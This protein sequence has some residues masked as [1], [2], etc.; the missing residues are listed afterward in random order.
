MTPVPIIL[1]AGA[2]SRLGGNKARTEIAGLPII[3][4]HLQ[5]ICAAG[6]SKPIVVTGSEADSVEALVRKDG[7]RSV[8]NENWKTGQTS[9]LLCGL[10]SLP[11]KAAGFFILPV[12]HACVLVTDWV[13]LFERFRAAGSKAQSQIFRPRC[14]D[15]LGHPVLFGREFLPEFL[16]LDEQTPGNTVYRAHLDQVVW[17][18]VSNPMIGL[19]VDTPTARQMAELWFQDRGVSDG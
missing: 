18:P 4:H 2:G 9:S 8:R 12:D 6:L 5:N 14:G 7:G 1:A 11:E 17:V 3:T 10:G 15:V 13:A 19:D 16:A